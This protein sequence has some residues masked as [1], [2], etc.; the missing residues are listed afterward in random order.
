ME[1]LLTQATPQTSRWHQSSTFLVL[2]VIVLSQQF[3]R[4][5]TKTR[6]NGKILLKH[7]TV[8]SHL[9][10]RPVQRNSSYFSSILNKTFVVSAAEP[11]P[12]DNE[13][14]AS[15]FIN[16]GESGILEDKSALEFPSI[17]DTSVEPPLPSITNTSVESTLSSETTIESITYIPPPP[18]PPE[19]LSQPLNALGEPTIQSLGLGGWSPVGMIQN[20][21]DYLHVSCDLPWW[22]AIAIATVCIRVLI[23]PLV[24]TSQKNAAKMNNNLPQLQLLQ[25]KMTEA[26]NSGNQ[27][28]SARLAQEMMI[29]MKEKDISP[30]KNVVVP[31]AQAPLFISMFMGLRGMA[32][33]PLESMKEGG[34]FWFVDLTV[35]DPYYLLPLV[36][37]TTM[38]A[39]IELGTDGARMNTPTMQNAKWV[40]R[41]LPILVFPFT[42]NFPTAVLCYWVSTNLFSLIQVGLLRIPTIRDF[43]NIPRLVTHRPETLPHK[44]KGMVAGFKESWSNMRIT[45]ELEERERY[46]EMRFKKAGAGPI[47]RTFKHDP[48][49]KRVIN[50]QAKVKSKV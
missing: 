30:M 35:C 42:I 26:R 19:A 15:P 34:L 36:T 17:I 32:N 46:D 33:L 49:K 2:K 41:A 8:I 31:L 43:F 16:S 45:K 40:L 14:E 23:F 24:I 29:F 7:S 6:V 18:A 44:P 48:T 9:A 3:S 10:S 50:V 22:G 11:L 27:M 28:E 13:T 37:A 25:M 21:L 1:S 38:L 47:V 4:Y 12:S 39:T 20:C 5:H